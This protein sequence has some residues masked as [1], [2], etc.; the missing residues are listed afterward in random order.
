VMRILPGPATSFVGWWAGLP[1]WRTRW[2]PPR[3]SS[4][5]A[6]NRN[7]RKRSPFS[8]L[9]PQALQL[10]HHRASRAMLPPPHRIPSRDGNWKTPGSFRIPACLAAHGSFSNFDSL[11]PSALT[12]DANHKVRKHHD[13]QTASGSLR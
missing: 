8:A 11:I 13:P 1:V 9:C 6:P 10:P 12:R 4:R 3:S 5:P 2:N 7:A